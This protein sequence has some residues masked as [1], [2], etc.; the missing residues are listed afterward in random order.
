M[1]FPFKIKG[2]H[3]ILIMIQTKIL[4]SCNIFLNLN[5]Y[6]LKQNGLTLVLWNYTYN[7][8]A[9]NTNSRWAERYPESFSSSKWCFK[10]FLG[11]CCKQSAAFM[12]FNMHYTEARWKE[13]YH[14]NFSK[15][16]KIPSDKLLPLIESRNRE[17]LFS[18]ST[19]LNRHIF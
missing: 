13:K 16:R 11:F 19:D 14:L 5:L 7:I 10:R 8:S 1:L 3:C 18:I 6:N 4:H 17:D 2:N 12:N 9:C 15:D